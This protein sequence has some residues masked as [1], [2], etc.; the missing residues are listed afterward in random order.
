MKKQRA[1]KIINNI[2]GMN[3]NGFHKDENWAP[4]HQI[5][6][7]LNKKEI[8][9]ILISANYEND[10]SRKVWKIEFPFLNDKGKE[11]ILYGQVI[12]SGAGMVSNPLEIYDIVGYC[13]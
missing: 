10:N 6:L 7:Q 13:S 11:T 5:F 3:S 1:Q 2:L 4:I 8:D 9:F 12:A